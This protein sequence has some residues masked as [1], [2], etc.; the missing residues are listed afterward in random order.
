VE[1]PTERT[2]TDNGRLMSI[3]V[4]SAQQIYI[5]PYR[6]RDSRGQLPE[7]CVPRIDIYSLAVLRFQQAALL[8]ILAGIM[9]RQ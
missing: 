3:F 8:R 7:K 5:E 6:T 4:P 9:T 1:G 2:T